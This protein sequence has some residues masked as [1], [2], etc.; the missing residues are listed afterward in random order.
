MVTRPENHLLNTWCDHFSRLYQDPAFTPFY[1]QHVLYRI[2]VHQAIL[3][4]TILARFEQSALQL[5]PHL[6]NYPLH[7]HATYPRSR[8]PTKLNDV[9]TTRY[10]ELLQAPNWREF[11]DIVEPLQSWL[12]ARV[13]EK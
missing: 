7:M 4:G 1:A 12:V 2:F 10:D 9:I 5:L 8:R 13:P 3:T 6:I 11:I